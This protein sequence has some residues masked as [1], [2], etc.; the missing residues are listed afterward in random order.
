MPDKPPLRVAILGSGPIGLEA[1]L[2]ARYLG[3]EVELFERGGSVGAHMQHWG[4][5][6][7][8]S[9][10]GSNATPLGVAAI[11]A[12]DPSWQC[13][14]ASDLLLANEHAS[15]YSLERLQCRTRRQVSPHPNR[16]FDRKETKARWDNKPDMF[17]AISGTAQRNTRHYEIPGELF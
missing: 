9:P 14:A 2:Y 11:G 4:H 7:L 17:T 10:F 3:Y 13:P 15:R 6:R 5:V 1:T 12:Q 8:F 16:L